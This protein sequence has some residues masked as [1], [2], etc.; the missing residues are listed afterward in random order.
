L[1]INIYFVTH[2]ERTTP[3][4][5]SKILDKENNMKALE[6]NTFNSTIKRAYSKESKNTLEEKSLSKDKTYNV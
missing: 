3:L 5:S 2:D 6:Q 4:Q 1:G